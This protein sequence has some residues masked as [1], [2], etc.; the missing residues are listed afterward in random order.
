MKRIFQ[1]ILAG[2]LL[3]SCTNHYESGLKF[4]EEKNYAQA[5]ENLKQ[6]EQSEDEF[7]DAQSKISEIEVIMRKMAA[8][9]KKEDSI[10]AV[11]Q[12]RRDSI[13]FVKRKERET[14]ELK[15]QLKREIE[16]TRNF[17]PSETY[18]NSVTALQLEVALFK[19]WGNIIRK[20]L[21]HEDREIQRLGNNLKANVVRIQRSE[22]PKIRKNYGEV[23]AKLLWESN[24]EVRAMGRGYT[25][26]EFTA[27]MFANN[28][29]KKDVQTM[30]T[31]NLY[32]F[33]F[34]QSRYKWY[35]YD[36]EYTY[37]TMKSD[38]DSELE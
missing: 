24:I 7:Q 12:M 34:K 15:E 10:A 22:F 29:N 3:V 33:R 6:V 23:S 2:I 8:E 25:I 37:Y 36:D 19:A 20:A 4:Y 27:G 14:A 16:D 1:I 9:K 28:K 11:E 31:D 13:A 5:L 18:R 35:E 30:L 38:S 32:L 26:L 17:K 21:N